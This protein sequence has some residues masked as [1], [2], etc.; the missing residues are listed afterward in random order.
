M[1]SLTMLTTKASMFSKSLPA[2]ISILPLPATTSA[3]TRA[4]F[5]TRIFCSQPM[6]TSCNSG[7][8]A[9]FE[10]AARLVPFQ[11]IMIRFS[12]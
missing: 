2:P 6:F 4:S 12:A 3:M 9:G 5:S 8:V 7:L 1:N 10:V 11:P